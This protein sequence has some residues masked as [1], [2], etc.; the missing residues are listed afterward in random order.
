[1]DRLADLGSEAELNDLLPDQ[2]RTE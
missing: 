2:W 1:L